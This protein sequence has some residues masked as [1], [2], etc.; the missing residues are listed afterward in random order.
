ME[1]LSL[2][3]SPEPLSSMT[4]APPFR[5]GHGAIVGADVIYAVVLFDNDVLVDMMVDAI[6]VEVIRNSHMSPEYPAVQ[7]Q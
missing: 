7:I 5:Q 1:T 2:A 6:D 3:L 4:Q